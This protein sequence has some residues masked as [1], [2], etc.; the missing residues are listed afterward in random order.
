MLLS[1]APPDPGW[2]SRG[3][4]HRQRI[5]FWL[6]RDGHRQGAL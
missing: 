5:P 1:P 6:S 2:G 4:S 3:R